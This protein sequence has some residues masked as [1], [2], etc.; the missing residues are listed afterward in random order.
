VNQPVFGLSF[1]GAQWVFV[2]VFFVGTIVSI[3]RKQESQVEE[4]LID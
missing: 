3:F 1:Y 4:E 2:L